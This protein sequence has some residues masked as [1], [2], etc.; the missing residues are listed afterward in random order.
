VEDA[1]TNTPELA[2]LADLANL[3]NLDNLDKHARLTK[4]ARSGDVP[5]IVAACGH[6]EADGGWRLDLEIA[7][8]GRTL[9][10]VEVA[11]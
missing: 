8:G 5:R 3:A 11:G 1:I 2:L 6:S 4:S 7:H 10:G 9:D